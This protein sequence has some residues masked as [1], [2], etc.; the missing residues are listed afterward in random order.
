MWLAL[1]LIWIVLTGTLTLSALL[2]GLVVSGVA[3]YLFRE[4]LSGESWLGHRERLRPIAPEE[5]GVGPLFKRIA[6]TVAFLPIFLWKVLLSGVGMALLAL[7][8]SMDFWPGIVRVQGGLRTTT[9]TTLFANL[10]TLTPGTMTID[11]DQ[12]E[13]VLYLHWIDITGYGE[14]EYDAKVTSGIRRWMERMGV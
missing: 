11:Y 13:D 1:S 6:W 2:P 5:R 14:E 3:V 7:R 12:E 4:L 8:P 9:G 10:L